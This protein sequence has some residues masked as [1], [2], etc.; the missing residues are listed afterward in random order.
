[1]TVKQAILAEQN[2]REFEG[3]V[4]L[5]FHQSSLSS[6]STIVGQTIRLDRIHSRVHPNILSLRRM[7]QAFRQHDP[8]CRKRS[9]LLQGERLVSLA[10]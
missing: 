1:M 3:S 7:F 4:C 5:S 10:K 8:G 9:D 6:T 2:Q